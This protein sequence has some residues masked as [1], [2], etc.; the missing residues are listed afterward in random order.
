MKR[1]IRLWLVLSPHI[2]RSSKQNLWSTQSSKAHYI[3]TWAS[4]ILHPKKNTIMLSNTKPLCILLKANRTKK[5]LDVLILDTFDYRMEKMEDGDAIVLEK[6]IVGEDKKTSIVLQPEDKTKLSIWQ[7][8]IRSQT[9]NTA[10]KIVFGVSL[11]SLMSR[12]MNLKDRVPQILNATLNFLDNDEAMNEVGI[13]RKTGNLGQIERY[14]ARFD[15]GEEVNL[16]EST[17]EYVECHTATGLVKKWLGRLPEPLLYPYQDFINVYST[18]EKEMK[19]SLLKMIENLP[20]HSVFVL[21]RLCSFLHKVS[22]R[23]EENK[24][25]IT[26]LALVVGPNVLR[27]PSSDVTS[28]AALSDS[29][30]IAAVFA[31]L[32]RNHETITLL[33]L[34]L[35]GV[36]KSDMEMMQEKKK[37]IQRTIT[38][39]RTRARPS[40]FSMDLSE[41]ENSG[42]SPLT[43]KVSSV[44]Q[45]ERH[46]SWAPT[47][48]EK[49]VATPEEISSPLTV[50]KTRKRMSQRPSKSTPSPLSSHATEKIMQNSAPS[51]APVNAVS[52]NSEVMALITQLQNSLEAE[53]VERR[54]LEAKVADLAT[55]VGQLERVVH[56]LQTK[57]DAAAI[58]DVMSML[59]F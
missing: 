29:G 12:P 54:K 16:A 6:T 15:S 23:E 22:L 49:E 50:K 2:K 39:Q 47:T 19:D 21:S 42:P 18:E 28:T 55:T 59:K 38:E 45:K 32:I 56:S 35:L 52:G 53:R 24:M 1:F 36:Q 33:S 34:K 26:N 31:T 43:K 58:D 25:N 30:K 37:A 27:T 41:S 11:S 20:S 9:R 13:F 7:D 4:K 44:G 46:K 8:M 17:E 10:N 14:I 51:L 3:I 5:I 57:N 40:I 48:K